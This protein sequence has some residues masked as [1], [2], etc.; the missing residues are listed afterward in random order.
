LFRLFHSS[1][2]MAPSIRF[3]S[4]GDA[5]IMQL[6]E[7]GERLHQEMTAQNPNLKYVQSLIAAAADL[8]VK[9]GPFGDG[10]S[11]AIGA[12]SRRV[13]HLL[14][15]VTSICSVALVCLGVAIVR[16]HLRR[17]ERMAAALRASQELVYIE[18]E[19]SHVTLDSIADAV[20][21][22]DL[23]R[24]VTYMNSAAEKL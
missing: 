10:Y 11:A 17:S 18:Q 1:P 9:V 23:D 12:A 20:I 7:I 21:S 13:T 6:A 14:L 16:G 3:W 19:R 8:H 2:I 5:L 22:V 24:R 15:L 4:D